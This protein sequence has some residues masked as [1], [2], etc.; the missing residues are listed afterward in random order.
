M[1]V[2]GQSAFSPGNTYAV[3]TEAASASASAHSSSVYKPTPVSTCVASF[4]TPPVNQY[5]S[6]FTS[7]AGVDGSASSAPA[8]YP[9]Y[10]GNVAPG[11]APL[12]QMGGSTG[13]YGTAQSS[14]PVYG[15]SAHSNK[16]YGTVSSSASADKQ[17]SYHAGGLSQNYDVY[18]QVNSAAGGGSSGTGYPLSGTGYQTGQL[19]YQGSSYQQSSV[20]AGYDLSATSQ[21]SG[22]ASYGTGHNYPPNLY[23][24]Q[25][26]DGSAPASNYSSG[27]DTTSVAGYPRGSQAYAV[28]VPSSTVASQSVSL[29]ANKLADNLSKLSVK[30]SASATVT[31]QFDGVQLASSS[32]SSASL[33]SSALPGVTVGFLSST[34]ASSTAARSTSSMLSTKSSAPQTSKTIDDYSA[35]LCSNLYQFHET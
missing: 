2:T 3:S 20:P 29:T 13:G 19:T 23:P 10:S 12:P 15:G 9:S 17:A 34:L 35:H 21:L 7:Y 1:G 30:E 8:Q 28:T 14:Q 5:A 11:F 25:S 31:G 24:R 4:H 27:P 6:S 32:T 18:Q 16:P 26:R 33:S 22:S